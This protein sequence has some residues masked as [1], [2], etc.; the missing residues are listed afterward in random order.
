MPDPRH[1]RQPDPEPPRPSKTRQ[2]QAM[3]DLQD[4]GARLVALDARRLAELDLP[5][6]L[7]DA[8]EAVRSIKA[9]EGRRRQMQYI[10]RLMRDVDA[11]PIV[12]ALARWDEGPR[13]AKARFATLEHWR[14]HI[15]ADDDGLADYLAR[16]PDAPRD[17]LVTLVRDARAERAAG[18]PPRD[19][20]ALFRALD[21][22]EPG[23][24]ARPIATV[25][26]A[27]DE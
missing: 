27:D 11:A 24:D 8:L 15:L 25:A 5:E 20:R 14:D 26:D 2:K 19:F 21:K 9:H 16:H 3:L 18:R 22:L 10:G 6:R 17:A 13:V 1:S 12:A 7:A 4:L 23:A